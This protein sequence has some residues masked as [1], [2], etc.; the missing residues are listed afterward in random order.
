MSLRDVSAALRSAPV[1]VPRDVASRA[2]PAVA[3]AARAA[4]P[5]LTGTLAAAI[6]ATSSDGRIVLSAPGVT[7][8]RYVE[9]LFEA[10]YSA[11]IGAAVKAAP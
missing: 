8:A 7:Y 11:A 9:G 5:V 1:R 4:A 6:V 2:A 10:D 3:E